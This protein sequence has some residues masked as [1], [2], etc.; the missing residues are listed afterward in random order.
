[1][2]STVFAI[3][4]ISQEDMQRYYA[5]SPPRHAEKAY[6]PNQGDKFPAL[7]T[8]PTTTG[9]SGQVVL[10][11]S[12]LFNR[13]P[14]RQAEAQL[15]DYDALLRYSGGTFPTPEVAQKLIG[16][17]PQIVLANCALMTPFVALIASRANSRVTVRVLTG[18]HK[19]KALSLED[20]NAA[21]GRL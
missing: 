18:G 2:S 3:S 21:G 4:T 15:I 9:A 8:V 17:Y 10:L 12:N 20:F 1:M 13:P 7:S 11:V 6:Q 14:F 16:Q 19:A 5:I